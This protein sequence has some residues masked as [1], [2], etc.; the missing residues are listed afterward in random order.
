MRKRFKAKNKENPIKSVFI[1]ILTI[2]ITFLVTSFVITIVA[3]NSSDPT[4]KTGLFSI[5]SLVLSGAIATFINTKL[6]G[7]ENVIY[8]FLS[9]LTALVIFMITSLIMCGKISGGTL[10]SA[11]CFTL[12][13][14]FAIFIGKMKKHARR[15]HS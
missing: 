13:A 5:I 7:K 15:R 3:Y 14:I 9:S 6:Y 2:F 8:P 4:A 1:G 11:L 12:A 10:M